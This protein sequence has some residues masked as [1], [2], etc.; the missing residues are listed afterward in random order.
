RHHQAAGDVPA[1]A[2]AYLRAAERALAGHATAEAAA[3]ASAGLALTAA[4]PSDLAPADRSS[5]GPAT[6]DR[7]S[8]GPAT[9]GPSASGCGA[10]P[11]W[12]ALAA[13]LR[14]A[15]A[16]ARAAHGDR[17]AVDDLRAA[18]AA[19]P[20]GPTR[21]RR[22]AR[23]AMLTFGAQDVTRASELAELAVVEAGADPTARAAALETA[24][25]VDMN[26]DRAARAR[27]RAEA[28]L[29]AYR[30][31]GDAAGV[32]RILDG[33]AMATFLDGRIDEGVAT[34]GRVA[35]LFVDSGELLRAITPRSTRGH[36]L[37]FAGAPA[38]GLD[39][40]TAAVRL[41]RELDTA[42]GQAYALWH[43]SEALSAL[44]RVDEA[45]ADAREALRLAAGHRGWTATAHRALGI[46]LT[47]RGELDAAA[48]AFAVSAEVAGESLTLF[49]SWAAARRALVALA[50]G[51]TAGV[52]AWVAHALAV[53]PP[54]GHYEARLAEVR[55]AQAR[56][57]PGAAELAATAR[58]LA[59]AGGHRASLA[60]L[61]R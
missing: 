34:F 10:A 50:A 29:A 38:E 32:A 26:T 31:L 21:S 33:R 8:T 37:V 14:A 42:E 18:L 19:T 27:D 58:D 57:D 53:G 24:A 15:R 1:A 47:A 35:Q 56:G 25:I 59:S 22:L 39:E 51:T 61:A 6:A 2:R 48:A 40:T 12:M 7:S 16:E 9:A 41:A 17:G 49:A 55:L 54:L 43:R 52:A 13:D 45:E 11:Q 4:T 36:G 60:E 23:L 20:P 30:R 5:T 3:S 44:G 46:A 28:A